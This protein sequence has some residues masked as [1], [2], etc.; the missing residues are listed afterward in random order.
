[1]LAVF[2]E[3]HRATIKMQVARS[4]KSIPAKA[5]SKSNKNEA[6]STRSKVDN[7]L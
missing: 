4:W 2:S 5:K 6:C 1:M 3:S 7:R